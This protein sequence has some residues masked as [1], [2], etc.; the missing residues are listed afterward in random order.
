MIASLQQAVW[1]DFFCRRRNTEK[2]SPSCRTVVGHLEKR[3]N[4]DKKSEFL[5]TKNNYEW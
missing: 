5:L 4:R 1:Q 2:T 3:K